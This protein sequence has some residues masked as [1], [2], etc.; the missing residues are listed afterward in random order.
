MAEKTAG[1]CDGRHCTAVGEMELPETNLYRIE[2]LDVWE[3][4]RETIHTGV[5]RK[6]DLKLPGKEE[7]RC[8]Q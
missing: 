2:V 6:V 5:N 7:L 1:Y 3:M 4:T 8:L